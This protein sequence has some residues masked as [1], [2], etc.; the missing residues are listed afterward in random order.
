[1][2]RF[3]TITDHNTAMNPVARAIAVHKLRVRLTT[4]KIKLYTMADGENCTAFM[5]DLMY[6]LSIVGRGCMLQF[7]TEPKD[8]DTLVGY[9]VLCG[10]LSACHDVFT[11]KGRW[12]SAQAVAVERA[13]EEAE[14]LN[15]MISPKYLFESIA[16]AANEIG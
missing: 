7:G 11:N 13:I 2:G 10:G 14:K 1:M 15:R 16:G 3:K 5:K 12:D 9:R 4:C 8:R 6:M